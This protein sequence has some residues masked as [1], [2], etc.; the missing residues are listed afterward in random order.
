MAFPQRAVRFKVSAAADGRYLVLKFT[1]PLPPND[2]RN[3]IQK[4]THE[5]ERLVVKAGGTLG[6]RNAVSRD[7]RN[8]GFYIKGARR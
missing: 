5:I 3:G 6:Q 8:A 7:F 2:D 4:L 1:W